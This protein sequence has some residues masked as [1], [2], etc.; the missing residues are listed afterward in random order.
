MF[1]ICEYAA[2]VLVALIGGILLFTAGVMCVM[3]ME[4]GGMAWRRWPEL[5]QRAAWLMGGWTAEPREP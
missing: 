1:I 2:C 3:L 5:T 4:A